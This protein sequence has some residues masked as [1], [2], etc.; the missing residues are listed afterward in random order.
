MMHLSAALHHPAAHPIQISGIKDLEMSAME[1]SYR[2]IAFTFRRPDNEVLRHTM[3]ELNSSTIL[4]SDYEP[5]EQ[6][7]RDIS[8][9]L[10]EE[11]P[12]IVVIEILP[13]FNYASIIQL[14]RNQCQEKSPAIVCILNDS[15]QNFTTK[16]FSEHDIDSVIFS[17]FTIGQMHVHLESANTQRLAQKKLNQR[18]EVA[19]STAKTAMEAASEI[20]LVMHMFDWLD[21]AYVYND[22]AK[23]IFK[24]C[25]NLAL[26]SVIQIVDDHDTYIFP[27]EAATDSLRHIL[28]NAFM[29]DV[30]I[31]SQKRLILIRMDYLVL[32]V[33]NAPWEN[34]ARYGRIRDLL[35]QIAAIAEAKTRTIM[36]NGLIEEQHE[37]VMSIMNMMRKLSTDTQSNSREIMRQLSEDLEIA[38]MSLDLNEHQEN[39][40]LKLSEKALDS[41]ESLYKTSDALEGHFYQLI[42]SLTKVREL[43][44]QRSGKNMETPSGESDDIELF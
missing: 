14:I 3:K 17:P 4:L 16:L 8:T 36:V 15:T 24:V 43:T 33:T 10:I 29:S 44:S 27:D 11:Q 37:K 19:S 34:E 22:V 30:R 39:H 25:N 41:L 23:C 40:L 42:S 31:V 2:I 6:W 18:I 32:M 21:S 1:T 13:A 38:A 9:R 35:V 26:K 5:S 28:A 12:D 7:H 20:G